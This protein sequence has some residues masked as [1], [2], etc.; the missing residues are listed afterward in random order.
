[1]NDTLYA[2]QQTG[3]LWLAEHKIA[4]LGDPPGLGKTRTALAAAQLVAGDG[5][6]AV[7]CPAIVREH[8]K[9]EALEAQLGATLHVESY[10]KLVL[11]PESRSAFADADVL[12][13]DEAHMLKHTQRKRT[14]LFLDSLTGLATSLARSTSARVWALSGTPMPRNPLEMYPILYA[15]WRARL[16]EFGVESRQNYLERYCGYKVTKYGIKV[17][18]AKHQLELR[19]L[20]APLMLRRLVEDV[21]PDLPK[22]R[23]SV[24]AI[25]KD[26]PD[27]RIVVA[28]SELDPNVVRAI[29][30]D[31]QLPP[32]DPNL[33]RYRHVLGDVKA[34]LAAQLIA[35]ELEGTVEKRVVF[36]HHLSVLDEMHQRLSKYGVVRIDGSTSPTA[37]VDAVNAFRHAVGARVFLGQISACAQGLDGLQYGAHEAV[38]VEPAWATDVNVQAG[39]RIGRVG[40]VF[41]AQVRMLALAGTLDDAIIRN[42]HREV[43]MTAE[44]MG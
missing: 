38:I 12:I 13:L 24:L 34:P 42:H 30:Y 20:I 14:R 9:N 35:S 44:I 11:D 17:L 26:E 16:A 22:L 29:R 6:V 18:F 15:L 40:Q 21:A 3:A 1:M 32:L 41:P 33:S 23:W 31:G 10:Q 37:R 28:E 25:S 2:Y 19:Q 27:P 4:Y 39:H 5:C 36:A 7:A 43:K 8:W